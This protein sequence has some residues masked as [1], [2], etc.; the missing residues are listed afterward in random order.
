MQFLTIYDFVLPGLYLLVILIIA[1][2]IK[3]KK[4]EKNPEYKYF[5]SGLMVKVIGGIC[6]VLVYCFYYNGGDTVAYI[7]STVAINKLILVK[8]DFS[9][10]FSLLT[11]HLTPE[12]ISVFDSSTGWPQYRSDPQ[13]FSVLRFTS[14]LAFIGMNSFMVTTMLVATITYTGIWRLFLLFR[15]NFQEIQKS[16]AIAILFM[17]SVFFWGSGILKDSYTICAAAWFIVSIYYLF[18][19]KKKKGFHLFA[20]LI[21]T[22]VLL[23]L[24]PYIF[25]AAI[26]GCSIMVAHHYLKITKNIIVKYTFIPFLIAVILFSGVF[27]IT[28]MGSSLGGDYSSVDAML[29]KIVIMQ[30]DLVK[31]YYGGNTFDIGKFEPTIPG[32]LAKAP[33]AMIA[34][35]F[36]PFLW[37]CRNPI[38]LISGIENTIILFLF[39]YVIVLSFTA[40]YKV[41]L[42]YMLKTTFDNSLVIFSLVFAFSFAFFVG[43]STANFGALVRYKIPLIPFL[44]ASLFIIIRKYNRE[45][46]EKK[47]TTPKTP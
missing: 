42:S 44:M 15:E 31:D 23:S 27:L 32:V 18:F 9:T 43:I 10:Y 20:L 35:I 37:E 46:E 41:G 5:V 16:I 45:K 25:F 30:Q 22:Y 39:F 28:K 17:P 47:T 2:I 13:S 38:M 24:K 34:G 36:R 3:N 4:I 29:N 26:S 8:G 12:N 1:V 6:V 7:E 21:S 11:G 19:K 40:V 14:I 33:A